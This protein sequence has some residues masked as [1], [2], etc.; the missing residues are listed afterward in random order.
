MYI[1]KQVRKFLE[2]RNKKKSYPALVSETADNYL[3]SSYSGGGMGLKSKINIMR[4]D[5]DIEK[6]NLR[7]SL[8]IEN[9]RGKE[10]LGPQL[11]VRQI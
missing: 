1:Y 9:E 10:Y 5:R 8:E 2:D 7:K 11:Q 4:D 3:R 6:E